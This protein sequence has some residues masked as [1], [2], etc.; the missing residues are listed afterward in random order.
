MAKVITKEGYRQFSTYIKEDLHRKI[1]QKASSEGRS[2][3]YLINEILA[4]HFK[5]K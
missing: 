5:E 1:K 2:I 4:T 3:T